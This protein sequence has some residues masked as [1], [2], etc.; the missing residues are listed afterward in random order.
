MLQ[1]KGSHLDSKEKVAEAK[2]AEH[3]QEEKLSEA[4]VA[5]HVQDQCERCIH[6]NC[7]DELTQCADEHHHCKAYDSCRKG[8]EQECNQ[9]CP[10]S[11]YFGGDFSCRRRFTC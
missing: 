1:V 4:K 5:G 7:E 6:A 8:A 11:Q 9:E 2:V 3:V 10:R